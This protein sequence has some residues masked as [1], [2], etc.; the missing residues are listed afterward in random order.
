[1]LYLKALLAFI[2]HHPALAYGAIF[3]IF[4]FE[5]RSLR[6]GGSSLGPAIVK[7]I[8][9]LHGGKVNVESRQGDWTRVTVSLPRHRETISA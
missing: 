5:S 3:L 4:L 1:M 8:I 9:E 2:T 7:K 6:Y